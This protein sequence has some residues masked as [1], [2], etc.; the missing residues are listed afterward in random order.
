MNLK[1]I[2]ENQTILKTTTLH[3]STANKGNIAN[4]PFIQQNANASKFEATFWIETVLNT[5]TNETFQQLQYSQTIVLDF[6]PLYKKPGQLIEWP[7]VNINTMI[8]N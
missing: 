1:K 6:F 3:V 2:I 8:K 5:E 4:I 7:H